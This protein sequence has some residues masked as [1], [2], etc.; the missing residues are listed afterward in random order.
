MLHLLCD[1]GCVLCDGSHYQGQAKA[2]A[3]YNSGL[4]KERT[5]ENRR[6]H[7]GLGSARPVKVPPLTLPIATLMVEKTLSDQT[8]ATQAAGHKSVRTDTPNR[9]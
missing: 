1:D 7:K 3:T 5:C 4:S 6:I 8:R 2:R 9:T